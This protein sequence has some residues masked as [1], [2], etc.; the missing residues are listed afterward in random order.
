MKDTMEDIKAKVIYKAKI[1]SMKI[2]A[3]VYRVALAILPVLVVY[4]VISEDTIPMWVNVI[5]GLLSIVPP[6]LASANTST[7]PP[8][9]M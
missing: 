6:A 2:R 5:G 3:W 1:P 9:F 8:S 4:G 7:K